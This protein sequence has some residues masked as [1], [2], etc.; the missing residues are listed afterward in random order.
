M[1]AAKRIALVVA[2][3]ALTAG[4]STAVAQGQVFFFSP[5]G[6]G[7][8]SLPELGLSYSLIPGYGY[9]VDYTWYP[10]VGQRIG[11]EPGDVILSINGR[12][13]SYAG[14]HRAALQ[15]AYWN[16]GWFSFAVRDVRTGRVLY[17]QGNLYQ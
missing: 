13:L 14:A 9:Q 4:A 15:Q 6:G 5:S 17:R 12:R 1:K 11:F 16:G 3:L 10:S 2:L 7:S 8:R